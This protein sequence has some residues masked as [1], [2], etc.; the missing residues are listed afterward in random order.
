MPV[1]PPKHLQIRSTTDHHN[2]LLIIISSFSFFLLSSSSILLSSITSNNNG[3]FAPPPLPE[4]YREHEFEGVKL[5]SERL[6]AFARR[7]PHASHPLPFF[8]SPAIIVISKP[9]PSLFLFLAFSLPRLFPLSFGP[10]SR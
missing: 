3:Q 1:A 6:V 2:T 7:K 10:P 4:S 8:S 9:L 5:P